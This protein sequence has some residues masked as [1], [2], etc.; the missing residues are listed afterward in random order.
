MANYQI[1][2]KTAY[3]FD[4]PV[5]GLELECCLEPCSD[6]IQSI[7][8]HKIMSNPLP[9]SNVKK[10]DQYGNQ[11]QSLRFEKALEKVEVSSIS[12]I[13]VSRAGELE[14]NR[15]LNNELNWYSLLNAD[16]LKQVKEKLDNLELNILSGDRELVEKV[17][18]LSTYIFE[19][20][21]YDN[22][23]T[24]VDTPITQILDSRCGVCQDFARV[25][26]AILNLHGIKACYVSGYVFT[27]QMEKGVEY[28]MASHAWVS[29]YLP[30]KGWV[31]IDPTNNCWTDERY[32]AMAIGRDYVDVVPLRG[33]IAKSPSQKLKV[34]VV[35]E[36]LSA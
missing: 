14:A 9:S 30:D 3:Y 36:K 22:S 10:R 6:K 18:G 26:I 20:F 28:Q 27:Q 15:Q 24:T 29:V 5:P 23:A 33:T 31:D 4:D 7:T 13:V 2:H 16:E 17:A 35:I 32:I 8:Y 1:T 11:K 34:S 25:M 12:N 19:H 21:S